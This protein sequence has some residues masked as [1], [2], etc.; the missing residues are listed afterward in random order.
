MS[1]RRLRAMVRRVTAEIRRDRPSLALLFV[2]PILITGLVTF[3]VRAGE[4]PVPSVVIVNEASG[5]AALAGKG[6]AAALEA[7]GMAVTDAPDED[8]ARAAPR[9]TGPP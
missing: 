6:M 7:D 1:A 4:A 9:T 2:A 5:P 8:A 3:I